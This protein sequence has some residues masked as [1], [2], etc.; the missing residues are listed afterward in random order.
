M[1]G[2]GGARKACYAFGVDNHSF[3]AQWAHGRVLD[4][5]CGAGELLRAFR[6][7]G[8][9]AWGCDTFYVGGDSWDLIGD[10]VRPYVLRMR[11]HMPFQDASFDCVVSN[12]LEPRLLRMAR[13]LDS[14]PSAD[15]NPQALLQTLQAC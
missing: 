15:G 11:E 4:Y 2:G 6:A 13:R 5:G 7:K 14:I 1:P 9:D 8:L 10:D 3:A 12:T